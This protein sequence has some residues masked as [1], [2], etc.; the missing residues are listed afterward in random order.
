MT[1]SNL[2][3]DVDAVVE[4]LPLQDGV[5]VVEPVFEVLVTVAEGDDDGD[6]LQRHAVSGSEASTGLQVRVLLLHLL[7]IHRG[8]ELH[9]QGP[10]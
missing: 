3:D 1:T 4:L 2:V 8:A 7:Q 9:P 10:H 6:L 5:Q